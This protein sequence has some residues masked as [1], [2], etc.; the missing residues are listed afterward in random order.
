MVLLDVVED[1][2]IDT[3]HHFA[4]LIVAVVSLAALIAVFIYQKR[5]KL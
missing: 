1:K 5:K 3:H 2:W 4:L